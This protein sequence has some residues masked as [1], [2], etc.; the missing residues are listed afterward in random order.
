M[1]HRHHQKEVSDVPGG[2]GQTQMSE[3]LGGGAQGLLGS[4]DTYRKTWRM[5]IRERQ[6]K[7]F[8][9]KSTGRKNLRKFFPLCPQYKGSFFSK[10]IWN[11]IKTKS[12]S[13]S[14]FTLQTDLAYYI[15]AS[16]LRDW[17]EKQLKWFSFF[18]LEHT[19]PFLPL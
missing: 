5:A 3:G 17:V 15:S 8:S 18:S 16:V 7:R 1:G 11:S 12:S 6:E 10:N 14:D 4:K 13:V 9:E 2:C 19:P